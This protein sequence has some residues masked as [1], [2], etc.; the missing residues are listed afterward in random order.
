MKSYKHIQ[1]RIDAM[2]VRLDRQEAKYDISVIHDLT[3]LSE[4]LE[5]LMEENKIL[6]DQIFTIEQQ[7][8]EEQQ[9]ENVLAAKLQRAILNSGIKKEYLEILNS[10]NND[11]FVITIQKKFGKTPEQLLQQ[12]EIRRLKASQKIVNLLKQNK[13]LAEKLAQQAQEVQLLMKIRYSFDNEEINISSEK[14]FRTLIDRVNKLIGKFNQRMLAVNLQKLHASFKSAYQEGWTRAAI[15]EAK[16]IASE[17][18]I[19]KLKMELM[20]K[21]HPRSRFRKKGK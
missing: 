4:Q 13:Q 2:R 10:T 14:E 9:W 11:I 3:Y 7:V 5:S 20:K 6:R 1:S 15:S 19:K 21:K 18:E 16:A 17:K 12:S 8:P